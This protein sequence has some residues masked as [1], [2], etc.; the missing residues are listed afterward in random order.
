MRKACV[1]LC[2]LMTACHAYGATIDC[3]TTITDGGSAGYSLT[4]AMP[5]DSL[6]EDSIMK[7]LQGALMDPIPVKQ[8]FYKKVL[9]GV[10]A[11]V[12]EF[13]NVDTEF[14]EPQHYKFTTTFMS[15][16]TFEMYRIKSQSGQEIVFAPEARIKMGPYIGWSLLFLGY[17]VDLAYISANKKKELDLSVYSS[18]I[19]V[20]FFRRNSGHDYYIRDWDMG[21]N[22]ATE[23]MTA[24]P[25]DGLNVTITGLNAYYIFNHRKFSYPA[26][27][28]QSTCQRKS[29]G[30]YIMGAGYT[31]HSL[32]LD[33][34]KLQSTFDHAYPNLSEKL[35]SGLM[36]NKIRY[37]DISISA[38]YGYN[39]VFSKNWLLSVC[40]SG[41]VGYKH[42]TGDRF[43]DAISLPEFSFT[44]INFDGVGRLGLIWNN[45]KWYFGAY[46][47][48]H[49]YT[50]RK[51][52]FQTNNYF[53]NVNVYVGF[54]FGR[55]KGHKKWNVED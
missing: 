22:E 45:S 37:T 50:Y 35:D 51:S 27:F 46:G 11:V 19:G 52:K 1:I 49:S 4:S 26:A 16:Y 31:K 8:P 25:F 23:E 5:K 40:I 29:C 39:W 12:K 44:N 53:G 55:K 36:F 48:V 24:I 47:V 3:D 54:N 2:L 21:V 43:E 14:I 42:A 7:N 9:N 13:N 30:S 32:N 15:T 38:G 34:T 33:Y 17:T 28:S 20:D 18:M 10:V 6:P 41:A